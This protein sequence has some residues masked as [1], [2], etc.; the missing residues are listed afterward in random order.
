MRLTVYVPKLAALPAIQPGAGIIGSQ[1]TDHPGKLLLDYEDTHPDVPDCRYADRVLHAAQR[2][3]A[4]DP[5]GCRLLADPDDLLV[6]GCFDPATGTVEVSN[7]EALEAWIAEAS[8]GTIPDLDAEMHTTTT[9]DD[10]P[11]A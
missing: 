6:V 1:A 8:H 5:N 3:L 2:H 7:S 11:P 4:S 9:L 10:G